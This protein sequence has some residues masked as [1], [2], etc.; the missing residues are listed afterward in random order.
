MTFCQ[1]I[2][3]DNPR[4]LTGRNTKRKSCAKE[5][6]KLDYAYE[7]KVLKELQGDGLTCADT[8]LCSLK[9]MKSAANNLLCKT[10]AVKNRE[11]S[12]DTYVATSSRKFQS[13]VVIPTTTASCVLSTF[14]LS[15]MFKC[16]S[17]VQLV[18]KHHHQIRRLKQDGTF[19]NIHDS[20]NN[21]IT[22]SV[23]DSVNKTDVMMQF[24]SHYYFMMM[25][26]ENFI[27]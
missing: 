5:T 23:G 20:I 7:D 21:F 26:T 15:M 24:F 2:G 25:I 13:G 6:V 11:K 1:S 12:I 3:A 10:C 17:V 16:F 4:G 22:T 9:R 14:C 18:V 19:N 27:F 8:R